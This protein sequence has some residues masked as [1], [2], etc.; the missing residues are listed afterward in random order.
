MAKPSGEPAYSI[1]AVSKLTGVSCHALRIWERRYGFPRPWRSPSGQRR[2]SWEQVEDLIQLSEQLRSG[3]S[4]GELI[5]GLP[6]WSPSPSPRLASKPITRLRPEFEELMTR[7]VMGDI[8]G[9][10]AFFDTLTTRVDVFDL[11]NQVIVPTLIE[12]GERWYRGDCMVFEEHCITEFLR[13]KL[14][15]MI[16]AALRA[17]PTPARVVVVG[18]VLGER[19]E[20]GGLLATL[21]LE[22]AGWG[23]IYIGSDL[24]VPEIVRAVERFRPDALALS[25]VLSRN[26]NKRFRELSKIV[27]VPIFVGGRS[28]LNYQSLARR[29]GLIPLVGS[30]ASSVEEMRAVVQEWKARHA[31]SPADG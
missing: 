30:I 22:R 14:E 3:R 18:T 19:H 7:L 31:T 23:V 16:D 29:Y 20:G 25:F 6:S 1:S 4:I 10:E 2:Y 24:P 13:R 8:R 27:D 17:N 11:I 12:S 9:A 15:I 21:T 5:G 28:I 26:L